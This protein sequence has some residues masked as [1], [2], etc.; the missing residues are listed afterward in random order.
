LLAVE[1]INAS[2]G[3]GHF[4]VNNP[5][6]LLSS[7]IEILSRDI[8]LLKSHYDLVVICRRTVFKGS[9]LSFRQ[10]TDFADSTLL[11]FGFRKTP[12]HILRYLARIKNSLS[13]QLCCLLSGVKNDGRT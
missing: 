4:C 7:E 8:E 12:R 13:G 9:E 6:L 2:A 1:V 11:F 5:N 3:I 10:L